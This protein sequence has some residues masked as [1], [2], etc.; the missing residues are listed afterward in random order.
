MATAT[1]RRAPVDDK[2]RKHRHKIAEQRLAIEH[3]LA[4][5]Y[6]EIARLDAELKTIATD[7]GE[8]FK[9]DFGKLGYVSASGRVE[10]EFKGDVPVVIT[11]AWQALKPAERK[12]LEKD[13]LIKIEPQ[14]GKAS[15]G[16]VTVKML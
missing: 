15:N 1:S 5:D 12:R 8:P 7:A 16:R 4:D 9:E 2:M 11:E 14:W 3:R 10:A 6:A 13:G